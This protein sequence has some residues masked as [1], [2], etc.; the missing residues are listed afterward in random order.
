MYV[1]HATA[2]TV[3]A[4]LFMHVQVVTRFLLAGSPLLPW[5]AAIMTT[6][7]GKEPVPL[8]EDDS[9]ETLRKV[10]CRSNMR[11]NTDTILFQVRTLPTL[12]SSDLRLTLLCQE[13]LDT[14][15][16]RWVM[17][18]FLGYTLVGTILFCNHL[19]WT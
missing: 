17:M 16:A 13:K 19:P 7:A 11:S 6:R 2:M 8:C 12:Y 4:L 15:K 1:V 3:F 14:D 18:F 5:L 9:V 10:E